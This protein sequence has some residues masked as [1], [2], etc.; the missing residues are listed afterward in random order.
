M[1]TMNAFEMLLKR[2]IW[3]NN[4]GR[5][6]F[7]YYISVLMRCMGLGAGELFKELQLILSILLFRRFKSEF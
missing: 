1:G 6:R 2:M 7:H 5:K 3:K 4:M